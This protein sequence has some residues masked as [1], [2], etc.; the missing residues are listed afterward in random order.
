MTQATILII[1]TLLVQSLHWVGGLV[2][3]AEALN[4]LERSNLFARGLGTRRRLAISVKIFAWGFLALGG[5]G[6]LIAPLMN[7][8]H[9]SL[10]D[11]ATMVGSALLIV[12]I[13]IKENQI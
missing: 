3:L 8:G 6:A 4:K 5:A 10:Q 13:R 2:V 12:N 1:P 7:L 11:A 9:P